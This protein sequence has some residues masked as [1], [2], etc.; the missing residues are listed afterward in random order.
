MQGGHSGLPPQGTPGG[1]A[2]TSVAQHSQST[3]VDGEKWD[4]EGYE[5]LQLEK[6]L[7]LDSRAKMQDKKREDKPQQQAQSQQMQRPP[8]VHPN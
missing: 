4:H 7:E 6:I 5:Q 2:A 1:N 8:K 3:N